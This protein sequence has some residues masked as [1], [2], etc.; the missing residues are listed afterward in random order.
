MASQAKGDK[1]HEL[2]LQGDPVTSVCKNNVKRCVLCIILLLC[3][4]VFSQVWAMKDN[5]SHDERWNYNFLVDVLK[6]L[7]GH[8]SEF[9]NARIENDAIVLFDTFDNKE[10][11]FHSLRGLKNWLGY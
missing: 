9:E 1:L 7:N 11:T 4:L 6:W 2:G 5:R 10:L 3:D 8:D